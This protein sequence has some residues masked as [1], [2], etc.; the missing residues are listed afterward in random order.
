MAKFDIR[1]FAKENPANKPQRQTWLNRSIE[2]NPEVGWQVVDLIAEWIAGGQIRKDFPGC[3]I[4]AR[5]LMKI[6]CITAGE[7]TI[8]KTLQE[9]ENG[10]RKLPSK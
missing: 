7:T 6:D 2:A 10:Q 1:K 3:Y 4:F 8:T 9:F 5:L